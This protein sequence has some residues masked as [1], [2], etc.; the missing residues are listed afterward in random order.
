MVSAGGILAGISWG[1]NAGAGSLTTFYVSAVVGGVG[2]GAVYSACIGHAL[3]W[4]S[5]GRGLAVGLT[6]AGFGTVSAATVLPIY[7]V[8]QAQGY[9]N[10]FLYFGVG[11]GLIILLAAR[12]LVLPAD[13]Y[14]KR[15]TIRAPRE[16][17]SYRPLEVAAAPV[18]WVMYLVFFLVAAAGLLA[19]SQLAQIAK[20]Y[21]VANVPVAILDLTLPALAFAL[22]IDRV[23]SGLSRPFFGWVSDQIGRE[24]VMFIAFGIEALAIVALARY[25]Q[26]PLWFV[27]LTGLIFFAWGE[28]YSLFPAAC[29]DAFGEKYAATHAGM[30]HTAKGAAALA[31]VLASGWLPPIANWTAAIYCAAGMN[32]VASVLAL[33][34]LK[35]MRAR[36]RAAD[37]ASSV[38]D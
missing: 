5:A 4:F 24:N 38:R 22:A 34:L 27:L 13:G 9:E 29:A 32:A 2:A 20:D 8:I 19:I 25:G 33:F 11:Q 23:F 6:A 1:L 26:D 18:F 28:I 16:T 3:K 36:Q 15:G 10:A 7:A 17:R 12:G 31:V 35:P 37:H 14:V 21:S 30:L